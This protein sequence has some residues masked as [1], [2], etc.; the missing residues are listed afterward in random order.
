[1]VVA[2]AK[3]TLK[4]G[5]LIMLNPGK[6]TIGAAAGLLLCAGMAA[7]AAGPAKSFKHSSIEAGRYR[8]KGVV[9]PLAPKAMT[10]NL[11]PNTIVSGT[12]V[13]CVGAQTTD[14]GWWRLYDLSVATGQLC[15][16]S[17]DFGIETAVG[18]TQN[19]TVNVFCLDNGLPFLGVF[20]VLTGTNTQPQPDVD[21]AFFN[22]PVAACCDSATQQMA[23]ELLSDNCQETLTCQSLFIGCNDLGQTAPSYITADDCGVVDPVDLAL[24]GFPDTAIIQVVNLEPTGD[25]GD[26]G[27]GGDDGGVPATTA[28]G[29]MFIILAL[30]GSSALFLRRRTT[31]N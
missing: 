15:T 4:G 19:M 1:M 16:T 17:V 21:L 6:S 13:A 26:S 28:P 3:E 30:L 10:Q 2:L 29:V 23:V 22:I 20:L 7:E 27:D 9:H 24:I 14:T 12:S 5:Y 18:P 8:V 25:G 31:D 11:D